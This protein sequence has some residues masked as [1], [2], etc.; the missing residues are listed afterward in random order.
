MATLIIFILG[1]TLL[2]KVCKIIKDIGVGLLSLVGSMIGILVFFRLLYKW[3][4][5][6][7][8]DF[9]KWV[10]NQVWKF[11]KWLGL[12]MESHFAYR[13]DEKYWFLVATSKDRN[14]I[15]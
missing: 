1:L 3:V 9:V 7:L 10:G 4:I 8:L 11:I 6:P 15:R 2:S 14:Q 13:Y 5:H 12:K